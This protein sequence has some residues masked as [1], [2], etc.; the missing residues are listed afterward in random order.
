[1]R[2]DRSTGQRLNL[3]SAGA[4]ELDFIRLH[5]SGSIRS[6]ENENETGKGKR[7]RIVLAWKK[8]VEPTIAINLI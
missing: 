2:L 8:P 4:V 7:K 6:I 5:L 1:M 3:H